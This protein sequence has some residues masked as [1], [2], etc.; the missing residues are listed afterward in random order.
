MPT[1]YLDDWVM[2]NMD[3]LGWTSGSKEKAKTVI[4]IAEKNMSQAFKSGVKV[5][6]GTDGAVYPLG[7]NADE[8]G[9]MVEMGLTPLPRFKQRR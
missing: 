2:H 1:V 4:A 7:L 9:T 6:F 3:S 5:A 8:F